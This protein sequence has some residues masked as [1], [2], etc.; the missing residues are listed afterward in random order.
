MSNDPSAKYY[1]TKQRKAIKNLV[2][3][4]KI[5]LKKKKKK[6]HGCPRYANF[7]NYF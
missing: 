3:G 5:C 7:S 6:K 4:N 1:Q 2:K